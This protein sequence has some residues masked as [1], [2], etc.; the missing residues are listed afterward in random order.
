MFKV[1]KLKKIT[2][3]KVVIPLHFYCCH[4]LPKRFSCFDTT[5]P[6]KI[7]QRGLLKPKSTSVKDAKDTL[8]YNDLLQTTV[9]LKSKLL[10][11]K[12]SI[13]LKLHNIKK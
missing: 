7:L 1:H 4:T 9:N 2:N 10:Y 12:V 3:N 11:F 5:V 6:F 8:N 13:I